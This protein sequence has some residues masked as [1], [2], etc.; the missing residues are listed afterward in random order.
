MEQAVSDIEPDLRL[1]STPAP[2]QVNA[3]AEPDTMAQ[4]V[5]GNLFDR[6]LEAL[7]GAFSDLSMRRGIEPPQLITGVPATRPTETSSEPT[8]PSPRRRRG[9]TPSLYSRSTE[10]LALAPSPSAQVSAE[11]DRARRQHQASLSTLAELF[12]NVHLL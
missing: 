2:A 12:P 5:G 6:P 9:Y 11:E 10:S 7:R 4:A 3:T 1:G 8:Q